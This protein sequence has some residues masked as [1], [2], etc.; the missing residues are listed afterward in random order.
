MSIENVVEF[1]IE[2]GNLIV[3]VDP[4]KDGQ[5]VVELKVN[6]LEV[7]DEVLSALQQVKDDA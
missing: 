3:N 4:N 7:P 1:S 6:L 5:N 2:G